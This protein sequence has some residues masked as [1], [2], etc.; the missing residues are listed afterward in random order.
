[1]GMPRVRKTN[2]SLTIKDRYRGIKKG[3]KV[4][5]FKPA[6]KYP[7]DVFKRSTEDKIMERDNTLVFIVDVKATKPEIKKAIA[8][9]YNAAVSKV[10]TL[11]KFK[12]P[13]KKA[14]VKFVEEGAAITIAGKAGILS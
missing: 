6:F 1:M 7:R 10:N 3:A 9:K 11:I 14:F 5:V 2:K 8:E 12:R 4:E 13:E